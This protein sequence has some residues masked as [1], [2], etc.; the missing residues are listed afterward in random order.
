MTKPYTRAWKTYTSSALNETYLEATHPS[1]L[2]VLVCPKELTTAYATLGIRY[3]ANDRPADGKPQPAGIAHFLEHK[4]FEQSDGGDAEEV[5]SALG[6]EVNAYTDED[7][8]AYLFSCTDHFNEALI[9]LLRLVRSFH[10]S[11]T[12]MER[13]RGII[14]EEIRMNDDNPWERCY[15]G[16]LSCLYRTHTVREEI[17]GSPQSIA[18]LTPSDLR[19]AFRQFYRPSDMV[20]AVSGRVTPDE[21]M[22]AV[23]RVFPTR[24]TRRA[25]PRASFDEPTGV[26]RPRVCLRMQTAKPL[27]CIGIKDPDVPTEPSVILLRDLC[28]TVLCEMLFSE[29]GEFCDSLFEEGRITPGLTYSSE[30]GRGFGFC[31]F[32]GEAD[33]PEVVFA[34]FRAYIDRLHRE[35]L[36]RTDFDRSRRILYADYVTGFDSTEDIAGNL[37]NYALEGLEL[38]DFLP[39]F[40]RVT[41]E[42]VTDLFHSVFREGQFVL[43]TVEPMETAP[44]CQEGQL[45]PEPVRMP[46]TSGTT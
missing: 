26:Y 10:V 27:F 40:D 43:A 29:S 6:A 39:A 2:R 46:E 9:A 23:D 32:A 25:V 19:E 20:L 5:F 44:S 22:D 14:A 42:R 17:C 24:K 30:I 18:A 45:P 41:F 12:S 34:R 31:F 11:V 4:M 1:G 7:R 33:D 15:A 28:M 3:G 36:S 35:G 38:F 16:M 13:E 37:L 8:T 21:V